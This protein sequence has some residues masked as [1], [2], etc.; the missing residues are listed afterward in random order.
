MKDPEMLES[1]PDRLKI[2]KICKH[3]VKGTLM[4]I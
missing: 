2:K 3:A 1:L 4:Q